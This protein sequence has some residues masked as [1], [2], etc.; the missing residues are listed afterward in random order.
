MLRLMMN[1]KGDLTDTFSTFAA[2]SGADVF[3]GV[4]IA[5][6]EGSLFYYIYL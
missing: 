5:S 6:A 1:N 2:S 3:T 4:M